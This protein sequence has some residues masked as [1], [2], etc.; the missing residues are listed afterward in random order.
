MSDL[1][2]IVRERLKTAPAGLHPDPNLLSAFAEQ[3]L[4]DRERTQVL[5]HLARC[6]ECRDVVALATPP[7]QPAAIVA[8]RDT[9]R[10]PKAPWFSWPTL[11]WGALAACVVIVGTAVLMQHNL[12]MAS[13]PPSAPKQ[14]KLE[15]DIF[16]EVA[17]LNDNETVGLVDQ[18]EETKGD[19]LSVGKRYATRDDTAE[20]KQSLAL[21]STRAKSE[22]LLTE[23]GAFPE[24][25][26]KRLEFNSGTVTAAN[27]VPAPSRQPSELRNLPAAGRNAVDLVASSAPKAATQTVEVEAMA[28]PV[29]TEQS[30]SQ[31]D[32]ALGKAKASVSSQNGFIFATPPAAAPTEKALASAEAHEN[33]R[34]ELYR[35][36]AD[37][38]RW[39]ISSDGQLQ[40]SVDSGKTWQPVVVAEKVTFRA[41]SA[42]GPDLWV[43]GPAGLLYH[44][45]DAGGH[46][47]QVKPT[48][49]GAT[50]TADIAALAFTDV[51]H[52]KLTTS[53]GE[54]WITIDAGQN[55]KRQP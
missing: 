14:A 33:L 40:H 45:T 1:P 18:K 8:G 37:V 17:P 24:V 25:A 13:A 46:W 42:N 2:N 22:K 6:G 9:V 55:W 16:R 10:V 48:T 47:A 23:T 41:L 52:G 28:G 50:L 32:E 38:G 19:K 54:V 30:A 20:L 27:P 21:P 43:G 39:T 26:K 53:T 35:Q 4:S 12:R 11:R 7:T 49:N 51:Q 3:A 31:K 36:H 29:K 44:S 15:G 34:A 5:D